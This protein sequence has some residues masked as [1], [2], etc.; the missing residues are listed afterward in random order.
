[1]SYSYYGRLSGKTKGLNFARTI[2]KEQKRIK[3]LKEKADY[4]KL[5]PKRRH[6]RPRR[7]RIEG[8]D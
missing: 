2:I 4:D 7:G 8:L 5:H 3:E 1:L 6:G